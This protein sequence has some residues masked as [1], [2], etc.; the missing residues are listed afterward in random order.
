[1]K[2]TRFVENCL[3]KIHFFKKIVEALQE[4]MDTDNQYTVCVL[5][6]LSNLNLQPELMVIHSVLLS[7][8]YLSE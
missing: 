2:V 7:F 3:R 4:K 5:D 1:M 6:A 8:H